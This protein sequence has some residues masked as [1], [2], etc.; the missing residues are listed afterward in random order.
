MKHLVDILVPS[1]RRGGPESIIN[2]MAK[3]FAD[4]EIRLRVVQ[5]VYG[6]DAWTVPEI[7]FC[8]IYPEGMDQN[9][10]TFINGY[11]EFL[12]S[13]EH[14]AAILA[15]SWPFLCYSAQV[16]K[17]QLSL[18]IPV[19]SWLHASVFEN[20][21]AGFGNMDAM[22]YADLHFAISDAIAS[23]IKNAIEDAIIYRVYNPIEPPALIAQK[24]K[25][26]KLVFIG[27]LVLIKRVDVILKA[28]DMT[29]V[30]WRLSVCGDGPE[31]DALISMTD[32]LGLKDRV[33]FLGWQDDPW[34]SAYDADYLVVA[35][36]Y[37]SFSVV[38][39]EAMS[40]GIPVITTPCEGIV[41]FLRDGENGFIY[42]YHD[43]VAL[44]EVLD[45]LGE[46]M[47]QRPDAAFCKKTAEPYIKEN[48]L[49][50][51]YIKLHTTVQ[52]KI[53]TDCMV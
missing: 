14:P 36:D 26:L 24:P 38:A 45:A 37:E 10:D 30:P 18:D 2:L 32:E 7:E 44:A 34:S 40:R 20:E 9:N 52:Q 15:T 53:L 25:P 47:L 46:D 22:R 3:H 13:H 49:S 43:P 4:S 19:I 27:R 31:R 42:P 51:F 28:L 41:E 5:M 6:G 33:E 1:A 11:R 23:E 48:A 35:S 8:S 16:V 50:D 29:G 39:I 17:S 21:K 12:K